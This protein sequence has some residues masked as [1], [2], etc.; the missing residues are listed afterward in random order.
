MS[1]AEYDLLIERESC[2]LAL[3]KT[4]I[5]AHFSCHSRESGDPPRRALRFSR[6]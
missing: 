1:S 4:V 3:H 5:P 2:P 6:R